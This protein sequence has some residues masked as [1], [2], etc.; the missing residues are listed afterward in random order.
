MDAQPSTLPRT[1]LGIA[2]TLAVISGSVS[3]QIIDTGFLNRSISEDGVEY[4][5]QVYVP[6]NFSRSVAWPVILAL[7]G[8]EAYGNDG[9]K[10]TEVGLA[11]A[12]RLHADR[13]Q[14]VVVFAQSPTDRTPGWHGLG[15]RAALGALERTVGEFN[16]DRSRLYLT[17][18]SAGGNGTWS[19]A[20]R[21]P[22]RFAALIVVAG[23]ISELQSNTTGVLYPAIAPPAVSD[24]F[25]AV[26][27]RI[28]K[29]P[30]WIFHGELDPRVPVE[31][32]RKMAAALKAMGADVRYT[33]LAG[34]GHN[35]WDDAYDRA[36]LF[37]WLFQQKRK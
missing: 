36:E 28:S 9:I 20:Y 14:A 13:F 24:P 12:I 31:E 25:T 10:Q 16:G 21:Y 1:L 33:E 5:Y 19:L 18:L 4:R 2:L 37:E 23:W 34:V 3:G 26:A 35:A 29:M 30:T 7:H 6:R 15:G 8:G 17:G 32:S 22:D 11:R 27:A